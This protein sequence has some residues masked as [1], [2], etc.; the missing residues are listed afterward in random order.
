MVAATI[1]R[2]CSA[3]WPSLVSMR[4]A[5]ICSVPSC[6][7]VEVAMVLMCIGDPESKKPTIF[8]QWVLKFWLLD[9]GSNQG[10]T[11]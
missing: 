6:V 9:L 8:R 7:R 10:P 5:A 11:D 3:M 4:N 2:M 1:A